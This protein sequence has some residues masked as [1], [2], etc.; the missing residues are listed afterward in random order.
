MIHLTR[1][2]ESEKKLDDSV[3]GPI[4]PNNTALMKKKLNI[5]LRY[6]TLVY[7]STL[8]FVFLFSTLENK[9]L[10]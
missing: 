7:Y 4:K 3:S 8:N 1:D 9:F 10:R 2:A 6:S 5:R